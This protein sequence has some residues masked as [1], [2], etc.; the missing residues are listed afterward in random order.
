MTDIQRRMLTYGT[1][2]FRTM[3]RVADCRRR[4]LSDADTEREVW[5]EIILARKH[6]GLLPPDFPT[7]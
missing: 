6:F 2:E 5:S 1:D 4:G 3:L 7:E